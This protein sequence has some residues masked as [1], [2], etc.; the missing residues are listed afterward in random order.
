MINLRNFIIFKVSE[1]SIRSLQGSF[2]KSFHKL[3]KKLLTKLLKN[4]SIVEIYII[5]Y[6]IKGSRCSFLYI[7]APLRACFT[8]L[9]KW[10]THIFRLSKNMITYSRK[11]IVE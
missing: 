5:M 7:G 10:L 3:H 6:Y 8:P 4:F 1:G 11:E 2:Q 9:S